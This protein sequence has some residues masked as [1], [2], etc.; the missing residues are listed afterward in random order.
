MLVVCW[1]LTEQAL[2]GLPLENRMTLVD[3]F[4]LLR[5]IMAKHF[6]PT[7]IKSITTVNSQMKTTVLLP[8]AASKMTTKHEVQFVCRVFLMLIYIDPVAGNIRKNSVL[9]MVSPTDSANPKA[10]KSKFTRIPSFQKEGKANAHLSEKT[11]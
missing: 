5:E 1:H 3:H 11:L 8:V 2:L 6:S 4:N 9:D 7:D 10:F